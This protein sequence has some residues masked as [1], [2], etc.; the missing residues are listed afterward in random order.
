MGDRRARFRWPAFAVK[1][2]NDDR[3]RRQ[4]NTKNR[5]QSD[6]PRDHRRG[7]ASAAAPRLL[8]PV[9]VVGVAVKFL[10]GIDHFIKFDHATG[11][12]DLP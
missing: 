2:G 9:D 6:P 11:S 4:L 5:F 10:Q 12:G 3:G 7:P 8:R 1:R